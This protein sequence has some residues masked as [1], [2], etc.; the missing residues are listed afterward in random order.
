M[1]LHIR[2]RTTVDWGSLRSFLLLFLFLFFL[3]FL[4]V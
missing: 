1:H 4:F 2:M 3:L